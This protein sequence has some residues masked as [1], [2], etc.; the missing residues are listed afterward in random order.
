MLSISKPV[1]FPTLRPDQDYPGRLYEQDAQV[2]IAALGYLAEDGTVSELS[3][4]RMHFRS[5]LYLAKGY[6]ILRLL[7][8][9]CP[10][11]DK[12]SPG[13]CDCGATN[14]TPTKTVLLRWDPRGGTSHRT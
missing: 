5:A 13:G 2:T 9:S 1:A 10:G 8:I 11:S 7:H 14:R 6:S 3:P 4:V 12:R